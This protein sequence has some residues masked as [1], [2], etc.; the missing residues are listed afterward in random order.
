MAPHSELHRSGRAGWLRAA[1][2]G[3][4]DG[5]VSTAALLVGV[6]ASGAGRNAI[7]TA[8]VAAVSAGAMSMAIGEY[9]SVSAQADTEAADRRREADEL[10]ADPSGELRELTTIY[11][12]RGLPHELAVEVAAALH[13]QDPLAAHLRDELGHTEAGAARPIQAAVASAA[14]FAVGALVPL[15]AAT[16]APAGLR[17]VVIAAITLMALSVLGVVGAALG[18]APRLRGALRVGVGG[19]LALALTYGI[20]AL[21]GATT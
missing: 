9:V 17:T 6:A 20:G 8:G 1:V 11:E 3:A 21:F 13:A 2:L 16:L 18:S 5:L 14:S 19:A 15:L 10:A 4:D 7:L 12:S